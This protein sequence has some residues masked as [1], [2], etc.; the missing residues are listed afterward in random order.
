MKWA[1]RIIVAISFL[2]VWPL[3][4]LAR[5]LTPLISESEFR[6]YS[7]EIAKKI[8]LFKDVW[9]QDDERIF[10]GGALRDYLFWLKNFILDHAATRE[11]ALKLLEMLKNL[12]EIPARLFM[13]RNSDGD[14]IIESKPITPDVEKWGIKELQRG[15]PRMF[16]EGS[17]HYQTMTEQGFLPIE[18]LRL[19]SQ[20]WI[21]DPN[22]SDPFE[23]IYFGD[24]ESYLKNFPD[25]RT[26]W[27]THF[28]ERGVNHPILLCL[29]M[30]RILSLEKDGLAILQ[31]H[32]RLQTEIINWVRDFMEGLSGTPAQDF[33]KVYNF[34]KFFAASLT[35]SWDQVEDPTSLLEMWKLANVFDLISHFPKD[36]IDADLY[37]TLFALRDAE[38]GEIPYVQPK[39]Q[40]I[41][42]TKVA[43]KNPERV[44]VFQ[45]KNEA[46]YKKALSAG[47]WIKPRHDR[48]RGL[49]FPLASIDTI[50]ERLKF[51]RTNSKYL[52]KVR[53]KETT[54]FV[55]ITEGE[56]AAHYA[57]T[58]LKPFK[59][60][61]GN[62]LELIEAPT[63]RGDFF[64]FKLYRREAIESVEPFNLDEYSNLI[65]PKIAFLR[66]LG[67]NTNPKCPNGLEIFLNRVF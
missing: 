54:R 11:E 59:Y 58:R 22:F 18:K 25:L 41:V 46:E 37:Q 67:L 43:D 28:A 12:D 65:P 24:Y 57:R 29:R 32:S 13:H 42:F 31:T 20:D 16:I 3:P 63:E 36:T 45:A 39:P 60:A 9:A 8:D 4:V 19:S 7:R 5:D 26:F 66:K 64:T 35:K 6:Y 52:I 30:I 44:Y 14:Y 17:S 40:D 38:K 55:N 53:L 10:F 50:N 23:A 62:N 34:R 47:F 48:D 21:V 27:K 51:P 1:L 2:S 49:G 15:D 56:G 33:L 61:A